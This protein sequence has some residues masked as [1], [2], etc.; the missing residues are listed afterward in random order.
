M[1]IYLP[2]GILIARVNQNQTGYIME[3]AALAV[4]SFSDDSLIG[5]V[6]ALT[7]Q[8]KPNDLNDIVDM[9]DV[10]Y[11]SDASFMSNWK[12]AVIAKAVDAALDA[13]DWALELL[14]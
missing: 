3:N 10:E 9:S 5:K 14:S 1:F 7:K 2:F 4:Q 11:G 8:M 13:E 12:A 6:T